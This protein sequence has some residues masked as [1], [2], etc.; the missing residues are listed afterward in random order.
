MHSDE[1]SR[2]V[3][4][5]MCYSRIVGS[6]SGIIWSISKIIKFL[7]SEKFELKLEDL[8]EVFEAS[9]YFM[10]DNLSA[11]LEIELEGVISLENVLCLLE[12]SRDYSLL[13]LRRS[14]LFYLMLNLN[15][16]KN[17]S[18]FRYIKED[19]MAELKRLM[20]LNNKT[21]K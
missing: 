20:A 9:T 11:L 1:L 6:K 14:C 16:A 13:F 8:I 7:N 15:E 4:N 3:Y 19:D 10:V 21:D 12:I 18:I 2:S 5:I 17:K